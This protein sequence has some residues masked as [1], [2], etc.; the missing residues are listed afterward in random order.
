MYPLV[1]TN[2]L[3]L[4]PWPS[5][6][7]VSSPNKKNAGSF[8]SCQRLREDWIHL[9]SIF[10]STTL[11]SPAKIPTMHLRFVPSTMVSPWL[12]WAPR[13]CAPDWQPSPAIQW[14]NNLRK[15]TVLL[16]RTLGTENYPLVKVDRTMERST[17]FRGKTHYEW[18]FSI[19]MFI[20][21]G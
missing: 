19:A 11:P 4:K 14:R 1:L 10:P 20:T 16:W 5:R 7:F 21:R 12:S 3:L 9:R 13:D 2:S 17:I 18:Q 15:P 8:H 6:K